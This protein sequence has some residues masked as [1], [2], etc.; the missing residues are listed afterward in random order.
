[1][2]TGSENA[3]HFN[4]GSWNAG[5]RNTGD[6]NTGHRNT[7]SW[8]AGNENTGS[9]NTG[10]WNAGNENAGNRNAGNENAGNENTGSWN[11]GSRNTGSRNT[12]S[13]NAGSRNTGNFNTL[14]PKE[15]NVFN[16]PCSI[17]DWNKAEKPNFIFFSNTV[18]VDE[19]DMTDVEREE[20][21]EWKTTGGYLKV[22]DYKDAFIESYNN[23]TE[24]DRQLIKKLP[25]FNADVFFEISGIDVRESQKDRELKQKKE[26]LIK[27][28]NEL[29][30]QAEAL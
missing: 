3:G 8:N 29:L 26:E 12:G 5:S 30:K 19:S 17:E 15:I 9:W 10:S 21:Q 27:K 16:K 24:E 18:W 6:G 25:N 14:T 20:H 13:W 4:T 11:A 2:N 1:M 22:S 28:A 23:T 7:G